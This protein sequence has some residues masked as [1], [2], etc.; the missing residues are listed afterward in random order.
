M[1]YY[2]F[3]LWANVFMAP[4]SVMGGY[5]YFGGDLLSTFFRTDDEF[6]INAP[7]FMNFFAT[8]KLVNV[9]LFFT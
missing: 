9:Y 5:Q 3:R 1:N 8:T 6:F 4:C 7:H 2:S